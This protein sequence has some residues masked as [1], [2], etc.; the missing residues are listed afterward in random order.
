MATELHITPWRCPMCVGGL[1]AGEDGQGI[2]RCQHCHGSGLTD[3]TIGL[4]AERAPRPPAVMRTP[5][6]DCAFRRDS[7]EL[8]ACGAQLP[9]EEPFFC[10]QGLYVSATGRYEPT[11]IFRG[12]PLGAMVCAG[13]WA[14]KTGEA[15]PAKPYREIPITE[16]EVEKR[17]APPAYFLGAAEL[18]EKAD[19]DV[20]RLEGTDLDEDGAAGVS[21]V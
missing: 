3:D 14:M 15:L 16:D 19:L 10:H 4:P 2:D 20:S 18:E 1:T 11:A 6:A 7:P 9:Y 8:E 13:W 12:L 17:W 21:D 5:C